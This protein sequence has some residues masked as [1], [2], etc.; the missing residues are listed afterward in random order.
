MN[1]ITY[2]NP[3]ALSTLGWSEHELLNILLLSLYNELWKQ[4]GYR[5]LHA[6]R[7]TQ[8]VSSVRSSSQVILLA[9][10][11]VHNIIKQIFFFYY[12]RVT[13][14]WDMNGLR[15]KIVLLFLLIF[16]DN[17]WPMVRITYKASVK[18]PSWSFTPA[19]PFNRRFWKPQDP[20][21]NM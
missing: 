21:F 12:S 3:L 15:L 5:S 11:A 7:F 4:W 10:A 19:L 9:L 6:G 13:N 18:L 20:L 8:L 2:L 16:R 1:L 17:E 14:F